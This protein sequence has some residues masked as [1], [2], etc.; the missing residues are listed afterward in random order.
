MS[1]TGHTEREAFIY[2][3]ARTALETLRTAYKDGAFCT[4]YAW[5]TL[6]GILVVLGDP[7]QTPPWRNEAVSDEDVSK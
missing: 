2:E 5:A 6:N 7:P 1:N 3:E 4:G